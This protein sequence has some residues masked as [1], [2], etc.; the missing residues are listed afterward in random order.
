MTQLI[1]DRRSRAHAAELDK[2][3]IAYELEPRPCSRA[4]SGRDPRADLGR[5]RDA[6][7]GRR[8]D[9]EQDK[10]AQHHRRNG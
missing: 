4:Y 8:G 9:R 6:W 1:T 2:R 7:L 10:P 5:I 3:G